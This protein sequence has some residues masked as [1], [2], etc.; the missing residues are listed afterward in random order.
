MLPTEEAAVSV[1]RA[2][3]VAAPKRNLAV[4]V[5]KKSHFRREFGRPGREFAP[6]RPG[7]LAGLP[8]NVIYQNNTS[9]YYNFTELGIPS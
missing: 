6:S 3:N 5:E 7:G 9:K 2:D 4:S 8:P 1:L